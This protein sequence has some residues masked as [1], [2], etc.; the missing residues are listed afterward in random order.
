MVEMN[1]GASGLKERIKAYLLEDKNE[2]FFFNRG[3]FLQYHAALV[4]CFP[5]M[6]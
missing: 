6:G 4:Y 5:S 2:L 3:Y 1:D